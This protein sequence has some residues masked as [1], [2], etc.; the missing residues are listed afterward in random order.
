MTFLKSSQKKTVTVH[1]VLV[2]TLNPST[3]WH[4]FLCSIVLIN[5]CYLSSCHAEKETGEYNNYMSLQPIGDRVVAQN[6]PAES[7]LDL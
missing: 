7:T 3:L 5:Q 2:S 1:C 6:L 4:I